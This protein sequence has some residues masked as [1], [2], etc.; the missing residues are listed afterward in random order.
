[1]SD[2]R[3]SRH[4]EY[5]Q[6]STSTTVASHLADCNIVGHTPGVDPE[7]L[8]FT[9]RNCVILEAN[10]KYIPYDRTGKHLICTLLITHLT[11]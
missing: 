10:N 6:L 7:I 11:N 4:T 2:S 3:Q 5:L 9:T 8:G 1:M